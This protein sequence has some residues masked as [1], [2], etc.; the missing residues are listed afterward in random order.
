MT[1]RGLPRRLHLDGGSL[2]GRRGNNPY[3]HHRVLN[4]AERGIRERI[5][6]I[7]DAPSLPFATGRFALVEEPI[8]VGDAGA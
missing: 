1:P 7:E 8:P 2:L 6:K 3:C 5:V 4:L